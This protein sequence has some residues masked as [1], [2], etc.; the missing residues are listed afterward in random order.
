MT[1]AGRR[2]ETVDTFAVVN[3]A[4]SVWTSEPERGEEVAGHLEVGMAL[5]SNHA[6]TLPHHPFAGAKWSGVCVENSRLGTYDFTR[7]QAIHTAR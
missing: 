3:P 7:V 6:V 5:V 4:T 1:I 2:A